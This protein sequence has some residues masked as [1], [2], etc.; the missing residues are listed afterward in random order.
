LLG[1]TPYEAWHGKAPA[2]GHLRTFGCLAF[3]KELTQLRKLDD[4]SHP[5]VFIGYADG[6]KEYHIL[7]PVTQHVRI[8]HDIVF[9]ESREWDWLK[10]GEGSASTGEELTIEHH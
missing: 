3:A 9:D 4:R 1:K 8:A 2:V 6:T 7:D 5:G 10:E